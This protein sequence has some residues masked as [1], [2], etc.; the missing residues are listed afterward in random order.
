MPRILYCNCA[1]AR[2]IPDHVKGE[3]L[4][5]LSRS[6][7]AFEAVADLCELSARR[8]PVLRRLAGG[9][10][11]AGTDRVEQEGAATPAEDAASAEPELRIAACYPRAVRWL[12]SAAG[13][14]LRENGVKI[15]NMRTASADEVV[16]SLLEA[17]GA[18][19]TPPS[20]DDERKENP[21]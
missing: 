14:P 21:A 8:S 13:A 9:P 18:S 16:A 2:V 6:G 20:A 1:Y 17:A 11:A 7:V 15:C 10:A 5:Q 19:T 12:F 4:E 3:V